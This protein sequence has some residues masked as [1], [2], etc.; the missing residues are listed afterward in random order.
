LYPNRSAESVIVQNVCQ[1]IHLLKRQRP[2][3]DQLRRGNGIITFVLAGV[4]ARIGIQR[5]LAEKRNE[6][7][8]GCPIEGVNF[9]PGGKGFEGMPDAIMVTLFYLRF[10]F[11]HPPGRSLSESRRIA[12]DQ[13]DR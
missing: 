6:L 11:S 7:Y 3:F 5:V 8:L 2:N 9:Q 13:K 1:A 10:T 4:L 12:N